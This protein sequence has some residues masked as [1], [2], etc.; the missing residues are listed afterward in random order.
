MHSESGQREKQR[1]ESGQE[2]Q[3]NPLEKGTTNE[4]RKL[5]EDGKWKELM[6]AQDEI[7]GIVRLAH[8]DWE[9]MPN[10]SELAK[11]LWRNEDW[12]DLTR[13]QYLTMRYSDADELMQKYNSGDGLNYS[14]QLSD[15]INYN[16]K[17]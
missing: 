2:E 1:E 13:L 16:R 9:N 3:L 10:I 8:K 5:A 15:E 7:I 14:H 6:N 11:T 4:M 12:E 17:E